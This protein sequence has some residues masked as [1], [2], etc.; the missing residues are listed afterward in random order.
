VPG[1]FGRSPAW[2]DRGRA[3]LESK[4]VFAYLSGLRFPTVLD[5]LK[6]LPQPAK[7]FFPLSV[8]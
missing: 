4:I 2:S 7:D 1:R 6:M 5:F 8:V 3:H